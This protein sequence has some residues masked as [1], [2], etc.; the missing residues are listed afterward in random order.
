MLRR[1]PLLGLVIGSVVT[2]VGLLIAAAGSSLE[3]RSPCAP[4]PE[5]ATP[6]R[7]EQARPLRMASVSLPPPPLLVQPAAT[8]SPATRPRPVAPVKKPDQ[9]M[10]AERDTVAVAPARSPVPRVSKVPVSKTPVSKAPVFPG[11]MNHSSTSSRPL[12]ADQE[13]EIEGPPLLRMLEHGKGPVVEIAWPEH[14]VA[15]AKLY[16]L[17]RRC[18]GLETVLL[19]GQE[20]LMNSANG[21]P[22]TF[23]TD[24]HSGFLRAV[25]GES[26]RR[27]TEILAALKSQHGGEGA[28][29][30]GCFREPLTRAFWAVSPVL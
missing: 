19:R 9:S 7:Q 18:H 14:R 13:R 22:E 10:S 3:S 28:R 21:G 30:P 25:M 24:R 8:A 4:N 6:T 23:D 2:S 5:T 15:R 20:I 12:V 29:P 27:E 26:P 1:S 17:L 11:S 16:E